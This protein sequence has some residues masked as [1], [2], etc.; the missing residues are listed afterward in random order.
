MG[1]GKKEES[2]PVELA[3]HERR[4]WSFGPYGTRTGEKGGVTGTGRKKRQEGGGGGGE[5][6][7]CLTRFRGL[8]NR[9]WSRRG[10]AV[11]GAA[12]KQSF[13]IVSYNVLARKL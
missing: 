2:R 3:R 12:E 6:R 11:S 7:E 9:Q 13:K 1:G 5:K 4:T 8:D 10:D